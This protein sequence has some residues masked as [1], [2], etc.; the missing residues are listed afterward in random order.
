ML[1]PEMAAYL[2]AGGEAAQAVGGWPRPD[3]PA[4]VERAFLERLNVATRTEPL[5]MAEVAD[6]WIEARGRRIFCRV[7]R[8]V[9]ADGLPVIVYFHGGGWYFS[10]VET[11]DNVARLEVK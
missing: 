4:P 5:P 7:Y 11:H 10:S 6:R 8:P 9:E 3:A 1:D 2:A